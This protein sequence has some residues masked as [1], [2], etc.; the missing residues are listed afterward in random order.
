M[1]L[2]NYNIY[3]F[4]FLLAIATALALF[5]LKP[6]F[7]PFL[8]AVIL[9]SLFKFVY[10]GIIKAT[11]G[12]EIISAIATCAIVALLILIPVLFVASLVGN[13][14]Y[15][16]VVK[17]SADTGGISESIVKSKEKLETL[18]FINLINLESY[19]SE[20]RA[21]GLVK[22]FSQNALTIIQKTYKGV[23]HFV[24][25]IV[26]TFFSLFYLL[27]DG[28]KLLKKITK[29]SPLRDEYEERLVGKFSSI[30][31]AT[32]KGTVLIAMLQGLMSGILFWATGVSSP[33]ILGI[34]TA[35][36]S[37]IPSVGS[38]LIWFPTGV[39]MIILGNIWPGIIIL[40]VGM[41][42]S[43]LDNVIKPK[44]VGQD[45]QMHPLLILFSTLGGIAIFGISGFII[46]PIIVSFFIVLWEIYAVEFRE[47]LEEFNK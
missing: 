4:F 18:P 22:S 35:I 1:K 32:I 2:K 38:A 43:T 8:L 44:L 47:Q 29:L 24:F 36:A 19:L 16:L 7:I 46:G 42:I 10:Q 37:V 9:T 12:Q 39:I 11:H 14:V 13:E 23:A 28:N 30:A 41:L 26:I 17:T 33:A 20:E 45:T 3:F 6:F 27:I 21:V 5:I 31:K 25:V 40:L 34:L 15:D